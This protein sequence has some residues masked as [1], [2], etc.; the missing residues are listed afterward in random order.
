MLLKYGVTL[1]YFLL[2]G[3]S[4]FAFLY[5]FY[6]ECITYSLLRFFE[7]VIVLFTYY[8]QLS[9]VRD[10]W[11]RVDKLFMQRKIRLEHA[12]KPKQEHPLPKCR[13]HSTPSVPQKLLPNTPK[14]S[15]PIVKGSNLASEPPLEQAS[16]VPAP[17]TDSMKKATPLA[18][19]HPTT[20]STTTYITTT[21]TTTRVKEDSSLSSAEKS[22]STTLTTTRTAPEDTTTTVPVLTASNEQSAPKKKKHKP[23][24]A[25]DTDREKLEAAKSAVEAIRRQL[26]N[27]TRRREAKNRLKA[28]AEEEERKLQEQPPRKKKVPGNSLYK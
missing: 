22:E 16:S 13:T 20:I 23:E 2:Y 21:T 15:K 8:N 25:Q 6:M 17:V 19:E 18:E 26:E 7:H 24:T 12:I 28:Q 10:T 14:R 5:T 9:D 1:C 11:V 27:E 3:L 4:C